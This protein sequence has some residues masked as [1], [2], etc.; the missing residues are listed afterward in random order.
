MDWLF[1][2]V[3]KS[4]SHVVSDSLFGVGSTSSSLN[5]SFLMGVN[6]VEGSECSSCRTGVE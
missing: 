5:K 1:G 6:L 2:G 3:E 4:S